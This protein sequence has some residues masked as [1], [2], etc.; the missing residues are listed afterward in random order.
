MSVAVIGTGNIGSRVARR[1]A[2]GGVDVTVAAG[3]LASAQEAA[4]KIGSGVKAAEAKDAIADADTVV[5]A[6]WFEVIKQLLADNAEA[7]KGKVVVDPS[8]NIAPDGDGFRN[9]NPEG[10]SA[11]QQLAQLMPAG[12]HYAKAFGTVGAE[13]LDATRT[14]HGDRIALYYATDDEAAGETVSDLITKGGWAPVR[15]GGVAATAR[16]EVFGD[17]HQFGGLAGRLL[18]KG[19]AQAELARS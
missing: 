7:L 8:N 1:L 12:A 4:G 10:V 15:A 14:E 6:T 18:S 2:Q 5:L 3:S 9:L 11:G 13:A 16:I 17:L 19:E